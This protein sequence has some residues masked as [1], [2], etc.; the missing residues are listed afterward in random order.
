[1]LEIL[2]LLKINLTLVVSKGFSCKL[3]NC[4]NSISN[5]AEFYY[6]QL[7]RGVSFELQ[8][9]S[10]KLSYWLW[11]IICSFSRRPVRLNT[12]N[13]ICWHFIDCVYLLLCYSRTILLW[14]PHVMIRHYVF[15]LIFEFFY[16]SR[17]FYRSRRVTMSTLRIRVCPSV[18][19]SVAR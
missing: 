17:N 10:S 12:T 5:S 7:H 14:L 19:L 2:I 4:L 6:S 3:L 16:L 8:V 9:K 1:M 13:N 18:H 11:F 15:M